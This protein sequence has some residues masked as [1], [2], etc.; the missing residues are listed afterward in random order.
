MQSKEEGLKIQRGV[1][2]ITGHGDEHLCPQLRHVLKDSSLVLADSL[3]LFWSL[4]PE[5]VVVRAKLKANAEVPKV[6]RV[7]ADG[8]PVKCSNAV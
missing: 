7:K 2:L 8:S 3:P 4:S 1:I 6:V 5:C